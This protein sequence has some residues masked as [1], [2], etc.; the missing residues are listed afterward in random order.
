MNIYEKVIDNI[1]ALLLSLV[2]F[3]SARV[4]RLSILFVFSHRVFIWRD[5]G[6]DCAGHFHCLL[7]LKAKETQHLVSKKPNNRTEV[8]THNCPFPGNMRLSRCCFAFKCITKTCPCNKQRF[9]SFKH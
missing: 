3:E 4:A 9:F 1:R 2:L 5:F 8:K 6:S 7:H